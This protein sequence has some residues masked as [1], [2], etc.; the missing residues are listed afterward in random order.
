MKTK[1][2]SAFAV[3]LL[4]TACTSNPTPKSP[5]ATKPA[6][7]SVIPPSSDPTASP[8]SVDPTDPPAEKINVDKNK[9]NVEITL[10]S[11]MFAGQ[12]L[13]QIIASA[14]A[15]GVSEVIK[16]DDGSISYTMSKSVHNDMMSEMKNGVAEYIEELKAST[17]FVSIKD[18]KHND[19][20]SEFD[21]IVD[22]TAYEGSFDAFSALAL[23]LQ[24]LFYQSFDGVKDAKVT[25]FVKD[26]A[27]GDLIDTIVYPD[28]LN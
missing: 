22:K 7:E 10:P 19:K 24:G 16:N 14:K 12:E 6:D 20:Y 23:G 25:V 15:D 2:I 28:A 13:D 1:L 17:D 8:N 26:E 5:D 4:L 18:V 21:L 9:S 3:L 27:S 11:S